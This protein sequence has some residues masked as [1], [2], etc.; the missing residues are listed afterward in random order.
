MR[1][2]EKESQQEIEGEKKIHELETQN[3]YLHFYRSKCTNFLLPGDWGMC[4][5]SKVYD[6]SW[7]NHETLISLSLSLIL[8]FYLTAN[9]KGIQSLISMW[10]SLCNL[11]YNV[12]G[13]GFVETQK[14]R[15]KK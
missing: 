8:L 5:Y 13:W 6:D 11:S 2:R 14:K 1:V 10:C 12:D 7:K 4:F 15:R 9:G 3:I